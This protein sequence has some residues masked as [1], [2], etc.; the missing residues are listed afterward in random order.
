MRLFGLFVEES[1]VKVHY[2]AYASD[3]ASK[4]V[5]AAAQLSF[6]TWP[7]DKLTGRKH[8]HTLLIRD[9]N[10]SSGKRLEFLH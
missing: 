2:K 5:F 9:S 1:L 6:A 7:D 10:P 3:S 4:L 8:L